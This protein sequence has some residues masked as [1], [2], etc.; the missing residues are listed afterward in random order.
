MGLDR[1][2][3]GG[4]NPVAVVRELGIPWRALLAVASGGANTHRN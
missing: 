2:T 4:I 1:E 3:P